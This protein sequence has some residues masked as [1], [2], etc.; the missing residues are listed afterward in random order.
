[1]FIM[2]DSVLQQII[3]VNNDTVDVLQHSFYEALK[4]SRTA[5]KTHG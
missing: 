4:T 1:M 3:D 5:K 2:G